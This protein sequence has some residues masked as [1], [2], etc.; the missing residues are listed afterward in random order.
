M[1]KILI[2]LIFGFVLMTFAQEGASPVADGKST[3]SAEITDKANP[4]CASDHDCSKT[5]GIGKKPQDQEG[6]LTDN[7]TKGCTNCKQPTKGRITSKTGAHTKS[8]KGKV[9]PPSNTKEV[10]SNQ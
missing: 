2:T 7:A 1:I 4:D 3:N 9:T 10:D 8:S 6:K 5:A